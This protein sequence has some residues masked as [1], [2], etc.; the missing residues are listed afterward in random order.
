MTIDIP[1]GTTKLSL[2]YTFS[3]NQRA[4]PEVRV[5]VQVGSEVGS[6]PEKKKLAIKKKGKPPRKHCK[7]CGRFLAYNVKGDYCYIHDICLC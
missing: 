3:G 2:T 6:E 1:E 4:E 7:H 5:Q